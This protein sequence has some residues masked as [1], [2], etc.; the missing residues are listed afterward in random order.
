M[1][2]RNTKVIQIAGLK[3]LLM[4]VFIGACLA[5]GFIA[6]PAICA[7]YIWNYAAKFVAIPLINIFQGL[8][9]WAIVAITAFIINEKNQLIVEFK[10]PEELSEQDMK[11]LLDRVKMHSQ[12]QALNSMILKSSDI[13]QAEKSD[14]SDNKSEK[15]KV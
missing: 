8:L 11:Q 15:E 13:K 12:A 2:K 14:K 10:A 6:F 5:A 9:L 1:R 3:G 7:M 4:V